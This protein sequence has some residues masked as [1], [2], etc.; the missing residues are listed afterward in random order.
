MMV[1]TVLATVAARPLPPAQHSIPMLLH[2]GVKHTASAGIW[3]PEDGGPW[4]SLGCA[5]SHGLWCVKRTSSALATL[6][7]DGKLWS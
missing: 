5:A 1:K 3:D 7:P 2:P 6:P 4:R